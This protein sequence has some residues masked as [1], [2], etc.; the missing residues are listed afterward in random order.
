MRRTAATKLAAPIVI[1]GVLAGP[2]LGACSS[3]ED[4][5][6]VTLTVWSL[7]NQT[8]RVQAAQATADKFTAQ[9]GIKVRVVATDE[10]QFTQLIT[11]SAAA[12]ELPDAI[13]ALSVAAVW[14][15]AAN[16]L[17]DTDAAG[18]V[19]RD[20]GQDTFAARTLE[21]T[22]NGDRQLAVPSDA[23]PMLLVY[24]KDLFDAAGLPAP[25]TF[26]R[27]RQAAQRLHAGEVAGIT[28]STVPDDAFTAQTFEHFGLGNDCQ[29]VDNAKQVKVDSP[30]CVDTFRFFGDLARQYSVAGAQG[31]DSTRATYFAGRAAMLVWSSFILDELA[32][33][34]NDAKPSCP[35]CAADPE[36]LAK[37]SG[38]VTTIK[39]PNGPQPAAYGELTSWVLPKD[40]RNTD[41]A[42]RYVRFMMDE[43]YLDW[44]GI[45]PE[46][47]FPA[48]EGN[49]GDPQRFVNG[50]DNLPAGVDTKRPLGEIYPAPV[51]EALRSSPGAIR[52]WGITEGQGE[53]VGATLGELVVPKAVNALASGQTDAAGAAKQAADAVR[54]IQDSMR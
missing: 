37:N 42:K 27:I 25:D 51:M 33:L 2:G 1:A 43:G 4:S 52:R 22:R 49:S 32:G 5:G 10:N 16:D 54:A 45:A 44:L 19:V 20:L 23:W 53:L 7:E 17:L 29:L 12:G 26:D 46:G 21:L 13:G 40:G 6:E 15:M 9:T 14:Q 18:E 24:R 28:M 8:E 41:A 11:S 38:F 50:W 31:V 30:S 39:G 36:W 34:R 35:Q 3:G 48:R 47:K